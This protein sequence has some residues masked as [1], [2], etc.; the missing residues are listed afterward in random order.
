MAVAFRWGGCGDGGSPPSHGRSLPGHPAGRAVLPWVRR[1]R[2]PSHCLSLQVVLNQKFTDC[3]VLVFLDSHLGKTVRTQG[4]GFCV[5]LVGGRTPNALPQ[6]LL[7]LG[8]LPCLPLTSVPHCVPTVS[9]GGFPRALPS[10]APGQREPPCPAG[11]HLPS[12][13]VGHQHSLLHPL[14][15]SPLRDGPLRVTVPRT[16]GL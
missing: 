8:C 6:S 13:R 12:P 10:A 14:D 7:R 5:G 11:L 4:E 15:P 3:F 1:P 16:V 9:D 2:S